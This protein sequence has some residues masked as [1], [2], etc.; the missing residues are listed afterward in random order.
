MKFNLSFWVVA[1]KVIY[2]S[3]LLTPSC[4]DPFNIGDIVDGQSSLVV[5]GL[6]TDEKKAHSV[7]ISYSS[8]SLRS[9]ESEPVT[10]ASVFIEGENGDRVQL[11]EGKRGEYLTP[12]DFAG[13]VSVAY[14]LH[15][16]TSENVS[17]RS[18]P[19]LMRPVADIDTV[20]AE[21]EGRKYIST[22]GTLL[23]EYGL[24][25]YLNTG[26]GL[27]ES[28]FY[29]WEWKDTYEIKAPLDSVPE[30]LTPPPPNLTC[31]QSSQGFQS[32][33]LGSTQNFTQDRII[34][35]PINFIS[36]RTYKLQRR[37]SLLVK[38]YSLTER[39]FN[40]W[41]DIEEQRNISGSL[42]DPPPTRIFGNIVRVD[43]PA[44]TIL[45]YFQ[46]SSVSEKRIFIERAD[47]PVEPG[48]PVEAFSICADEEDSELPVRGADDPSQ[49]PPLFCYDCR[50]LPGATTERPSFW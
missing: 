3:L 39:A 10:N 16:Q 11:V 15:I 48:G 34:R 33:L 24:Q 42:L 28:N 49:G 47:V 25:F 19:E 8:P 5:D 21:I 38:Q 35:Q 36:K 23:D 31:Y 20:F 12:P 40:F 1:K 32:L 41:S 9:Y 7:K 17:Y 22:I 37:Y 18:V 45:G 44:E 26:T 13:K 14:T 29:R 2:A 46:V 4:V 27:P 6:L 50:F 43:D 30:T